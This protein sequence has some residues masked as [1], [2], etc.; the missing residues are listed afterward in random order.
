[1]GKRLDTRSLPTMFYPGLSAPNVLLNFI[2]VQYAWAV[3]D[4]EDKLDEAAIPDVEDMLSACCGL[5]VIDEESEIIRLVHSTVQEYFQD[6]LTRWFPT[7]HLDIA[8]TCVLYLSFEDFSGGPV[9]THEEALARL[10]KP[11]FTYAVDYWGY[12]TSAGCFC[13]PQLLN[14]LKKSEW[15][16]MVVQLCDIFSN[17]RKRFWLSSVDL[18]PSHNA[19]H[20]LGAYGL[21][22]LVKI[23]PCECSGYRSRPARPGRSDAAKLG[24][25]VWP[26]G[27]C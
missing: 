5:V 13:T 14:L 25:R 22:N 8:N 17:I 7:A 4:S 3:K 19:F 1:M 26:Y 18:R 20:V 27:D 2:D 23:T 9:R 16:R 21:N 12:H 24:C 6:T 11:L 10:E 15:V